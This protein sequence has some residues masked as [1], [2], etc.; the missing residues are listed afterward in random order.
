VSSWKQQEIEEFKSVMLHLATWAIKLPV[1]SQK[2]LCLSKY[3]N[4]HPR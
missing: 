2:V 1:T 4:L 3:I